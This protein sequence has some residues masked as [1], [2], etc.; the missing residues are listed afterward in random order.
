MRPHTARWRSGDRSAIQSV[1]VFRR[2]LIATI[3]RKTASESWRFY[4]PWTVDSGQ[5]QACTSSCTWCVLMDLGPP[6]R[7]AA[8]PG[9]YCYNNPNTNL[10]L[11]LTLT[12]R[13]PGMAGRHRVH[14]H[15][16]RPTL[17]VNSWYSQTP[18]TFKHKRLTGAHGKYHTDQSRAHAYIY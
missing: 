16:S 11:T 10:T 8:I 12:P 15:C 18:D 1:P 3:G 2:W 17:C 14:G 4:C 5:R 13:I 7:R 9:Y 6:F